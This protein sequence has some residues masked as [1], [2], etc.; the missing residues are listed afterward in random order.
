MRMS[1]HGISGSAV[2]APSASSAEGMPPSNAPAH[3]PL[4]CRN[5]TPTPARP[6]ARAGAAISASRQSAAA[7]ATPFRRIP[8]APERMLPLHTLQRAPSPPL[9]G[10]GRGEGGVPQGQSRE[11]VGTFSPAW[12]HEAEETFREAST[13]GAPPSSHPSPPK[14]GEGA[15]CGKWKG[16]MP[17]QTLASRPISSP[18]CQETRPHL[19]KHRFDGGHRGGDL[20]SEER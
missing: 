1:D 16:R 7:S 10:E 8:G 5:T 11:Y 2:T 20:R 17:S 4:P 15:G 18:L 12:T 19:A 3:A 9:G 6:A 14:G 13:R